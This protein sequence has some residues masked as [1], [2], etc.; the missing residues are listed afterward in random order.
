MTY[1]VSN[2]I[3]QGL[4]ELSNANWAG[5]RESLR[6]LS[7][8]ERAFS[9]LN[10]TLTGNEEELE[11][12]VMFEKWQYVA[13]WALLVFAP[14]DEVDNAIRVHILE[15]SRRSSTPSPRHEIQEL[16]LHVRKGISI[17]ANAAI[18][19]SGALD[20]VVFP[21]G[22]PGWLKHQLAGD[23]F[24]LRAGSTLDI[25]FEVMTNALGLG[26]TTSSVSFHIQDDSYPDCF[27][28]REMNLRVTIHVSPSYSFYV[29]LSV[30]LISGF[31][32]LYAYFERK[33]KEADSVWE[34]AKSELIYDDPPE[35]LGRGTFGL[36]V[37][38]EYRG[39]KVAVKVCR[40]NNMG[41]RFHSLMAKL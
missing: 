29:V 14:T 1:L 38:A 28:D 17:V 24:H 6:R 21:G 19:N 22:T 12:Y 20:V 15:N 2:T 16:D 34:V 13:N 25:Q 7:P 33:R 11:F 40:V 36:V 8:G 30:I 32:A 18:Q 26:T 37:G 35:V 39:T 41:K 9:K 31:I 27:Y 23:G 10:I 5:L 4:T 3:Y